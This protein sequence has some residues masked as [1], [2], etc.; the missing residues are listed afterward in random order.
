MSLTVIRVDGSAPM[1]I[2][3]YMEERNTLL[4]IFQRVGE[5]IGSLRQKVDALQ[6]RE[7]VSREQTDA[8]RKGAEAQEERIKALQEQGNVL[9]TREETSR[10]EL[11]ALAGREHQRRVE[12]FDT[13]VYE[14]RDLIEQLEAG[15]QTRNT[16]ARVG[17]V[18]ATV[19]GTALLGPGMPILYPAVKTIAYAATEWNNPEDPLRCAIFHKRAELLALSEELGIPVPS[20]LTAVKDE[21]LLHFGV[22]TIL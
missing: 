10:A 8:L 2:A 5:E 16:A 13:L 4:E 21:S 22:N 11:A 7:N 1:P 9:R 19:L 6:V 18:A 20:E 3:L 14:C 15:K 12:R 17:A